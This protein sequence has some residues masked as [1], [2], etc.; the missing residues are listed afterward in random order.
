MRKTL[1]TAMALVMMAGTVGVAGAASAQQRPGGGYEAAHQRGDRGDRRDDRR[2]DSRWDRRDDRRDDRADRRD[3]RREDRAHRQQYNRWQAAQ[4]RYSA[5]RYQ[6]PRGHQTR[7]WGYGQRMSY[8]YRTSQYV[9]R[10]YNRYGLYAP[11]S[12]Y[13]YVRSGNDVVLA[14]VATGLITAVIAGL[15]Q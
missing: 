8:Q 15:F 11:P 13:H 4:R 3:D 5:Q 10:D 14:A 12:G 2:A 6:A 7:T 1:T 9:V